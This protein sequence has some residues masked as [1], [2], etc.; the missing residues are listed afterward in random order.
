ALAR[1][2]GMQAATLARRLLDTEELPPAVSALVQQVGE[3]NPFYIEEVMRSL[4]DAGVIEEHRGRP[5]LT[6]PVEVV[7]VPGTIQ[8]VIM[9]RVDRLDG[10]TRRLLPAAA[11]VGPI[12]PLPLL[13]AVAS[14]QQEPRK[15]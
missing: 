6:R 2:D 13:P 5:Q 8:E 1:L 12:F 11:V 3:G 14:H 9:A 7:D 15:R 10:P 4:R